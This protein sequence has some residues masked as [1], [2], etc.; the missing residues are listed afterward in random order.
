M[1]RAGGQIACHQGKQIGGLGPGVGPGGETVAA[2]G[3]VAIGQKDRQI[4]FKP[5]GEGR[6]DVGA[7]GVKG[8]LAKALRLALGAEQTLR[9]IEAFQLGVGFGVDLDLAVPGEGRVG[10]RDGQAGVVNPWVNGMPVNH[11]ADQLQLFPVETKGPVGAVGIGAKGDARGHAGRCRVQP[12]G[13]IDLVHQ[14]VRRCV[15]GEADGL[16][17]RVFHRGPLSMKPTAKL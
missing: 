10:D 5:H 1:A 4:A 13:Q 3:L 6:H 16:G 9:D 17:G 15:F 12:E 11:R 7:V 8:D 14:P 2:P